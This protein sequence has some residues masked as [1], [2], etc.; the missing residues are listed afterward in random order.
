MTNKNG[1][2]D[3]CNELELI[4]MLSKF[5]VNN[6]NINNGSTANIRELIE[7]KEKLQK[8]MDNMFAILLNQ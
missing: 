7:E 6:M 2:F 1:I 4:K 8:E 5:N 3:E